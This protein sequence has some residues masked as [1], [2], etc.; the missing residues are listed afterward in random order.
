MLSDG[1]PERI[2]RA[3]GNVKDGSNQR[4]VRVNYGLL[5]A[6]EI[7]GVTLDVTDVAG[8]YLSAEWDRNRQ[9]FRYPRRS[10]VDVTK[11]RAFNNAADAWF[12]N[13]YKRAYPYYAFGEVYNVDP[14]CIEL[15]SGR[16]TKRCCRYKITTT[17]LVLCMNLLMIMMIKT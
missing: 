13:V 9:H 5:V 12:L 11:H 1:I 17:T 10:E 15:V 3:D 16:N 8:F 14:D 7:F 2:V 6:N 4:F